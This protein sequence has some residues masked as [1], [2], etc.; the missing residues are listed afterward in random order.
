M[1]G[2]VVIGGEGK[3][4][5]SIAPKN[6]RSLKTDASTQSVDPHSRECLRTIVFRVFIVSIFCPSLAEALPHTVYTLAQSNRTSTVRYNNK[7]SGT[8]SKVTGMICV[9]IDMYD[10]SLHLFF[11][12]FFLALL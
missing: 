2:S 4:I 8:T 6:T 7:P 10:T 9:L 11:L 3:A 1:T 5:V 12:F